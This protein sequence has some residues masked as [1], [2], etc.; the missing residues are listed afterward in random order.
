MIIRSKH[1]NIIIKDFL[2]NWISIFGSPKK[3]LVIMGGNLSQ[4]NFC[5]NFNIE[6]STTTAKSP[7]CNGICE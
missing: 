2:Q 7:W 4:K 6:I 3:Y 1:P 5:E